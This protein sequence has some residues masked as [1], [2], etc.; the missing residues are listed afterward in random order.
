MSGK[1]LVGKTCHPGNDPSGKRPV[2]KRPDTFSITG[3]WVTF[4]NIGLRRKKTKNVKKTLLNLGFSSPAT[5]SFM[6]T[7]WIFSRSPAK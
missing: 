7:T 2:L 6:N 4:D 1:R 5:K 3:F